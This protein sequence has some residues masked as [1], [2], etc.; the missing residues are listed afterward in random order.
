VR[1]PAKAGNP[2]L[3]FSDESGYKAMLDGGAAVVSVF[4]SRYVRGECIEGHE[5]KCA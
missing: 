5:L 4:T 2:R 1:L 3:L